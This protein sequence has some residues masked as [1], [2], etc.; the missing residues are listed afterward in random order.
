MKD[1]TLQ[2]IITAGVEVIILISIVFFVGRPLAK[3]ARRLQHK[4]NDKQQ[5][6]AKERNLIQLIPNPQ[7]EIEKIRKGM[8]ELQKRA[9]T[10]KELPKIIQ[11][12]INKSSEL[13]IEIVSIKPRSDIKT[14][15]EKLPQGVSKAYIEMIIKCPYYVLGEYL[16]ALNKLPIMFTIESVYME[17]I[18]NIGSSS[19]GSSGRKKGKKK[20]QNIFV[21]LILST[22]TIWPM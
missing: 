8:N 17:K 2:S 20:K 15:G 16:K 10:K 5:E 11:Q 14:G 7:K 9:A 4:L 21:T 22:Y 1:K 18:E 3:Y 19:E 12:L 13:G 6:L